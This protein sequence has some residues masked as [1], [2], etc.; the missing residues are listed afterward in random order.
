MKEL[1]TRFLIR[2]LG[3]SHNDACHRK[4]TSHW[5][6]FVLI[7]FRSRTLVS[8]DSTGSVQFWDS[9][10]GTLLQAHSFHN[11][12]VNALVVAPS[13]NR[14]FFASSDGQLREF[15]SYLKGEHIACS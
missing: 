9:Q 2:N 8:G 15:L 14:V 10:H 5:H 6:K 12:N 7:Y 13:H 4:S 1:L 11:G 3:T